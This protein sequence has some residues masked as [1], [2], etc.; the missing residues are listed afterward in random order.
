MA[1]KDT[2]LVHIYYGD[3]KGKTTTGLGLSI[4]AAGCGYRVLLYQFMKDN[5]T[6]ERK[7][8]EGIANITIVDGLEREKFSVGMTEKEK[9]DRRVFYEEQFFKIT[10]MARESNY[11]VLFMDEIIY[12]IGAG[13]LDENVVLN[14]LKKKPQDLEVIMTGNTPGQELIELADYVSEIKKIKHPY[15]KGKKA[16]LGIEK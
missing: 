10:R 3:G 15:D 7:I 6:S 2:G 1:K 13:L 16:R 14:Y 9:K 11:D 8:L 4:R 12:T 5:G